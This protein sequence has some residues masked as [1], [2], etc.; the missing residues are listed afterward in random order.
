MR[1]LKSLTPRQW[2]IAAAYV[3]AGALFAILLFTGLSRV[4]STPAPSTPVPST[5]ASTAPDAA[6]APAKAVPRIKATL[7]F[8]SEDGMRLVPAQQDVAL[9]EGVVAQARSIV[10]AQLA[11]EAPPP[12]ASTIPKGSTLRG[13]FISERNEAFVDLD[14]AIKSAHPGGTLQ[15]LMTVYTIVNALMTNLPNLRE[16]QLL[17]GGQEVD[18]L[19][20]HVDLRRPLRKNEGLILSSV[21]PPQP[22]TQ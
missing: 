17:I 22:P 11:A 8:A 3:A 15:E 10:E 5:D 18:T 6:S 13:I 7:F 16:V 21:T 12:L 14:P 19:A 4:L 9:A 2:R 1:S 20:G